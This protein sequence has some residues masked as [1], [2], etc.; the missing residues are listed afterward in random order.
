MTSC[1]TC[2][3]PAVGTASDLDGWWTTVCIA[4]MPS[5]DDD[6]IYTA[7]PVEDV[8]DLHRGDDK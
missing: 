1:D 2:G 5:G 7:F 6:M 3:K 4:C 8:E